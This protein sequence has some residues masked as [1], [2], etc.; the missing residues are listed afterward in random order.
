MKRISIRSKM[1]ISFILIYMTPLILVGLPGAFWIEGKMRNDSKD[2]MSREVIAAAD[3]IAESFGIMDNY[4]MQAVNDALIKGIMYMQDPQQLY[5]RYSAIELN[6][7]AYQLKILSITN[8][9]FDDLALCFPRK[10]FAITPRGTYSIKQLFSYE[11]VVDGMEMDDWVTLMGEG[12]Q[13]SVL[14]SQRQM[15]TFEQKREGLFYLRNTEPDY[16]H[17]PL[18]AVLFFMSL[19]RLHDLIDPLLEWENT[20]LTLINTDGSV[21]YDAG[22]EDSHTGRNI[23]QT[24]VISDYGWQLTI[25]VPEAALMKEV[26][27]ANIL[28]GIVFIIMC[29]VGILLSIYTASKNYQPLARIFNLLFKEGTLEVKYPTDIEMLSIEQS[30]VSIIEKEEDLQQELGIHKELLSFAALSRLLE[31][32]LNIN[33]ENCIKLFSALDMPLPY[34]Y[35]SVGVLA[36]LDYDNIQKFMSVLA[37]EMIYAYPISQGDRHVIFFNHIQADGLR[38]L[39]GHGKV[40]GICMGLSN[41]R[42]TISGVATAYREA[43]EAVDHRP[44][45]SQDCLVFFEDVND[46]DTTF[47]Y[48]I[49]AEV[50]LVNMLR[51]HEIIEAEAE[52]KKLLDTNMSAGLSQYALKQFLYD[53]ELTCRKHLPINSNELQQRFPDLPDNTPAEERMDRI[54]QLIKEYAKNDAIDTYGD[55]DS[56]CRDVIIYLDENF[57]DSQLSL[58]KVAEHFHVTPAYLSRYIRKRTGIGYLEYLNRKRID[59]AKEYLRRGS[60]S[61]KQLAVRVGFDNDVTLRRIFK[62]YEGITPTQYKD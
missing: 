31:G 46:T 16:G 13:S 29:C 7:F 36:N 25:N 1:I 26:Y 54:I 8:D 44:V 11:F 48:P 15:T 37:D 57:S 19:D 12:F 47:Y 50:R 53:I 9:V 49:E 52:Y 59:A 33:T 34:P 39:V 32:T 2:R 17:K 35:F 56:L 51:A 27:D 24:A 21:L 5:E 55:I 20:T 30:L 40:F 18:F 23:T 22:I 28:I 43:L 6:N 61:I 10:N 41:P 38:E 14:I 42:N 62:K 3:K 60:I 45:H 4:V 58:T